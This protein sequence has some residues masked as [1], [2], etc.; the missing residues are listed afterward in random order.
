MSAGSATHKTQCWKLEMTLDNLLIFM[1]KETEAQSGGV[2][3]VTWGQT[4]KSQ[5][6]GIDDT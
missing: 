4:A 6:R 3:W 2:N 1:N 5:Y